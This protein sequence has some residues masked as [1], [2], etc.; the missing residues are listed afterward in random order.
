MGPFFRRTG[1]AWKI[2]IAQLLFLTA[3]GLTAARWGFLG[4]HK[5][6]LEQFVLSASWFLWVNLALWCPKCGS[7]VVWRIISGKPIGVAL[8]TFYVT[9][10]PVCS[11]EGDPDRR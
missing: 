5:L 8:G 11:F 7:A 1:Q 3:A 9:S 4:R 6:E 10:C 2:V